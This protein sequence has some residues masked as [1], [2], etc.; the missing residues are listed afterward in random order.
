MDVTKLASAP[1]SEA[2]PKKKDGAVSDSRLNTKE[3]K[4]KKACADFEGILL[5]YMFEAMK[6]TV[7]EGGVFGNGFR[8]DMYESMFTQA[9]STTLARGKGVGLGEALYRQVSN[10]TG[11]ETA[12]SPEAPL[13]HVSQE[14]DSVNRYK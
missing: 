9:V 11:A 2:S 5:N 3:A 14:K 1:I 10:R 8:K 7:G 12:G 13:K 4:L 6:K